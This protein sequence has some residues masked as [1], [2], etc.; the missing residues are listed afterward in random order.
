MEWIKSNWLKLTLLLADQFEAEPDLQAVIFLIGV[1]ELGR[2]KRD[3]SKQ[4]KMDLMH[5]ATCKLL[6]SYGYY[7]FSCYDSEGWPHYEKT[8]LIPAL[9][10]RQQDLMLK[11]AVIDYFSVNKIFTPG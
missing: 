8:S 7:K 9:S 5:I 3:F 1:Q 4:E 10:M 11:K 2:V 6:S